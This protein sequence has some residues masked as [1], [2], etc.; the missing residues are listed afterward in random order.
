MFEVAMA[1]EQLGAYLA[2]LSQ[3]NREALRERLRQNLF[4]NRPDGP[5]TLRAKAWAVKGIVPNGQ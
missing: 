4:G 5:F 3:A 1:Y 2:A